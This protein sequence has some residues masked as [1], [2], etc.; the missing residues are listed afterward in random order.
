MRS[1]PALCFKAMCGEEL[2]GPKKKKTKKSSTKGSG[3]VKAEAFDSDGSMSGD[4]SEGGDSGPS[5]PLSPN[6]QG[7]QGTKRWVWFGSF[8][9][10][11]NNFIFCYT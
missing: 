1:D 11:Y 6:S 5:T 2:P 7:A 9:K 8:A 4:D 10:I 3:V